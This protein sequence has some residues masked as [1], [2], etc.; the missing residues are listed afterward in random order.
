MRVHDVGITFKENDSDEEFKRRPPS[1][2]FTMY[3]EKVPF[4]RVHISSWGV[5]MT[6]ISDIFYVRYGVL[7]VPNAKDLD[8]MDVTKQVA[9]YCKN[10][11]IGDREH[12][13]FRD[14]TNWMETH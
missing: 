1:T 13:F 10:R 3:Y 9:L 11:N 6:F 5:T 12:R 8:R 4:I 7:D 14:V 2:E